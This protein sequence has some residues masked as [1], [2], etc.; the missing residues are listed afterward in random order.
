MKNA[1]SQRKITIIYVGVYD[2]SHGKIGACLGLELRTS[3][4]SGQWSA[5]SDQNRGHLSLGSSDEGV[6][7]SLRTSKFSGQCPKCK[8]IDVC[9]SKH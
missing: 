1:I 7:I 4:F 2:E 5:V 6:G 3:K 9:K 8:N